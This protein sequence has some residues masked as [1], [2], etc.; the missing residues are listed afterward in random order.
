MSKLK[1]AILSLGFTA[2]ISL[3]WA[4]DDGDFQVWHTENQEKKINDKLKVTTEE[5]F[6]FGDDASDFYYQ[7]YDLGFVF[8]ANKN[9]DFGVN[10]RQV[11]AKENGH[12]REENRPHINATLKWDSWGISFDDRNRLEYRHFYWK[13]DSW[14]YRNK[15]T[16]KFPWK[17]TKLEFQPYLADEVFFGLN[18]EGLDRNRFYSGLGFS[19]TQDIKAEIYYLLQSSKSS[20]IWTDAN[21]LGTKLK[22]VF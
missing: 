5:E 18:G 10:Y 14:R 19:F 13:E 1:L 6:R 21:V 4:F 15:F 12:F 7:H 3:A 20:G 22:L 2:I 9:F 8:A 16:M 17:F 11:L